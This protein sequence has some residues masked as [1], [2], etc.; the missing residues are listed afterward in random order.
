MKISCEGCGAEYD[1]PERQIPP[2]GATIKCP[3]CLHSFVVPSAASKPTLPEIELSALDDISV[4][5][6]DTPLPPALP[7]MADPMRAKVPLHP[8]AAADLPAPKSPSKPALPKLS[9]IVGKPKAPLIDVEA[10]TDD[11][12]LSIRSSLH[13]APGLLS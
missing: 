3:A 7:G 5:D 8:S 9:P 2:S 4:E 12:S 1:L 11:S 10:T 13:A 6:G